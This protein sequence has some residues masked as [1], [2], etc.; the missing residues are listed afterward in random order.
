[1]KIHNDGSEIAHVSG[2]TAPSA[3]IGSGRIIIPYYSKT[4]SNAQVICTCGSRWDNSSVYEMTT[5]STVEWEN[6]AAITQ[7]ALVLTSGNFGSLS[8]FRLYGVT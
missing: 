1:M 3:S 4:T 7:V 5:T 8:T 6:S 2:D